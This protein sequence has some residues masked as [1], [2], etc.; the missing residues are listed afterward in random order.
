MIFK[1]N[2]IN[3]FSLAY[4]V[5]RLWKTDTPPFPEFCHAGWEDILILWPE[6]NTACKKRVAWIIIKH[7]SFCFPLIFNMQQCN[8]FSVCKHMSFMSINDIIQLS[9]WQTAFKMEHAFCLISLPER[10]N[11]L[12]RDSFQMLL[13]PQ[14]P[15]ID[16]RIEMSSNSTT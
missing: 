1:Y 2:W 16:L 6:F 11:S 9:T 14:R 12:Q 5:I 10:K 8:I 15:K 4:L 3:I 13:S 7:S